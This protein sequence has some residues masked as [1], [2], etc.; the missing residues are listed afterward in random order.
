MRRFCQ[1]DAHIFCAPSQVASEVRDTLDFVTS[2]Y[3][4]LGFDGSLIEFALSTRPDKAIG[5]PEQWTQAEAALRDALSRS[6]GADRWRVDEGEG[7]FYGPKIDVTLRDALGRVQ[8]CGTVQLDFNLPQRFDLRYKD[9][10]GELQHVVMIHRAICGS[11]ERM[12]AMLAEHHGGAWPLWLAPQRV[13]V[14]PLAAEHA[15][16]AQHVANF[17]RSLDREAS[18]TVTLDDSN[19]SLRKRVRNAVQVIA[20]CICPKKADAIRRHRRRTCLSSAARSAT[21]ALWLCAGAATPS[22]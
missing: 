3:E 16:Y 8:Q 15:D 18:A 2:F 21:A 10:D 17:V 5:E 4:R 20:G 6:V 14:L 7:A 13:V 1:D 22:K 19:E 9:S 11:L 12:I